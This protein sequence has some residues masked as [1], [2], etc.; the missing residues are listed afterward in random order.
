MAAGPKS[1]F[2]NRGLLTNAADLVA[3]P[4]L[5]PYGECFQNGEEVVDEQNWAMEGEVYYDGSC[6]LVKGNRER[7][8]AAW[9][10]VQVDETGQV[11]SSM[12]GVVPAYMPQTAQSAEH[13]GRTMAVQTLCG[14]TTLSGDCRNV[15]DDAGKTMRQICNKKR[16]HAAACRYARTT[17]TGRYV[18]C[19]R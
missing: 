7:S 19:D 11:V 12:R 5:L 18:K 13:M 4:P 8:R 10:V 14:E 16:M 6:D 15:V 3:G 1:V 2:Y 9:A 17:A